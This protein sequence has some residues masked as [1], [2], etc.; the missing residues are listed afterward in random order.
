MC[1]LLTLNTCLYVSTAN[2]LMGK[3]T[4]YQNNIFA[5]TPHGEHVLLS[6]GT[7][8]LTVNAWMHESFF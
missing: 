2:G 8:L 4:L 3:S 5:N 7:N 1:P 6:G